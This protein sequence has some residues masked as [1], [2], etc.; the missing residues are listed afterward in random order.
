M[1]LLILGVLLWAAVHFFPVFMPNMRAGI[2]SQ[3]G[4]GPYKGIFSLLLLGSIVLMVFGWRAAGDGVA[5]DVDGALRHVS[6]AFILL[7]IILFAAAKGKSRIRTLLRHPML[8]GMA[9]WAIG[10]L[11]VNQEARSVILFGGMLLWAGIS[12][13]GINRREG[14]YSPPDPWSWGRE[15]IMLVI[16]GLV[17][18]G[19]VFAHPYLTGI[20]LL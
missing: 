16:A 1:I 13:V 17:Y 6:Y 7:G 19:L 5:F 15:V 20:P 11:L 18:L 14:A 10:H 12:I 9:M 8:T 4:E 3:V 2:M